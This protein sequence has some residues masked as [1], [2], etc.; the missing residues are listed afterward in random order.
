[1]AWSLS[2]SKYGSLLSHSIVLRFVTDAVSAS[3]VIF[4][5]L[6]L[7]VASLFVLACTVAGLRVKVSLDW[8]LML[9]AI[10]CKL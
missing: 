3:V 5:V 8:H 4:G 10:I 6:S 9:E 7:V 2:S 1:M